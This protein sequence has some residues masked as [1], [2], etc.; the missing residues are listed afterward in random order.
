[1]ET[2]SLR[3][4]TPAATAGTCNAVVAVTDAPETVGW[5]PKM[6]SSHAAGSA[7]ERCSVWS[8]VLDLPK[9][10][11]GATRIKVATYLAHGG[12]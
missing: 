4:F 10:N 11:T 9:P 12:G 5:P 8:L 2:A 6:S 7:R 3:A 1:M